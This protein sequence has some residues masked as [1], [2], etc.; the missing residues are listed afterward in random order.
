M[1]LWRSMIFRDPLYPRPDIRGVIGVLWGV[2]SLR[3]AG[4]NEG[5]F[6]QD[7][8]TLRADCLQCQWSTIAFV[9]GH[10]GHWRAIVETRGSWRAI[11]PRPYIHPSGTAAG[12]AGDFHAGK[13]R[14]ANKIPMIISSNSF[15]WDYHNFAG[16]RSEVLTA[17]QR[18][19]C[20]LFIKYCSTTLPLQF[21][22]IQTSF[23]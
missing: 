19:L 18:D 16:N 11:E 5:C 2:L 7:R 1:C 23:N 22:H 15:L 6:A 17:Q 12:G 8:L 14:R 13:S 10:G 9:C 21:I 20:L 3:W 4:L